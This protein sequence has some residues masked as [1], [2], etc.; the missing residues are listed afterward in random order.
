MTK[1]KQRSLLPPLTEK[2]RLAG[3]D[4]L[5]RVRAELHE[6][7]AAE[8]LRYDAARKKIKSLEG[9]FEVILRDLAQEEP[10]D[11]RET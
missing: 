10:E 4:S 7:E 3:L 2:Q 9:Q 11:D 5:L 1:P 6:A 8:K